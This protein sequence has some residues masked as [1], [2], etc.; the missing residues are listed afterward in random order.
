MSTMAV[1]AVKRRSRKMINKSADFFETFGERLGVSVKLPR[2]DRK[3]KESIARTNKILG[4]YFLLSGVV[5]KKKSFVVLGIGCLANAAILSTDKS[6]ET[7]SD[8]V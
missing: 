2:P 1:V 8:K 4:S 5:F 6:I 3:T 7:T